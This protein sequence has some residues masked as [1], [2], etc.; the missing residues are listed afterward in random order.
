M[1]KIHLFINQTENISLFSLTKSV[2]M[3]KYVIPDLNQLRKRNI[4]MNI[5]SSC[6]DLP[7]EI[8]LIIFK[9]LNNVSL[10]YSLLS[11]NKRLDK[12]LQDNIF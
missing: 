12:V 1:I 8:L 9:K 10:L 4:K 3:S 5:E 6:V 7:D 2:R 11:I